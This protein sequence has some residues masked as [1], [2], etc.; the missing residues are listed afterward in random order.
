MKILRGGTRTFALPLVTPLATAHGRIAS[1]D[2]YLVSLM[3]QEGRCGFGEATPLPEFG[4]ENLETSGRALERAL[5][6]L[7]AAGT[8]TI[9]DA[10]ALC[11]RSCVEA[12]CALSALDGALHDLAAQHA[13]RSLPDWIRD[14]AG[15]PGASARRIFV[16][17]LVVGEA[18]AEVSASARAAL[19][20]GFE[21]FKLKLA[22]SPSQRDLEL[23]LARVAA[24]RETVGPAHRIRLDANEAWTLREAESALDALLRFDI[25]YVEQPVGRGERAALKDLDTNAAVPVA[26]DEALLRKGW[27]ACLESRAASIFIV[28]PAALG[29]IAPCLALYRRARA[30]GIRIVWSSLIDGAVGRAGAVA[31]AAAL[32]GSGICDGEGDDEVHGLGTGR[33]LARDLVEDREGVDGEIEPNRTVGLGTALTPVWDVPHDADEPFWGETWVVEAGK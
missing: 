3:D 28:K 32:G 2:G 12:P 1:R 29:G 4:T 25:D 6:R 33:L 21:T 7:V 5:R 13:E 16:Q 31:L 10:L 20:E 23:D 27:E 17:A 18:P 24:L 26:A 9:E 8:H 15:L 30:L 19:D 11:S 22:V 14:R